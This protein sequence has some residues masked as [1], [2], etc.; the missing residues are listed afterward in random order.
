MP[1]DLL[2]T[3]FLAFGRFATNPSALLAASLGRRHELLA[4]S[5]AAV[6]AFLDR[7]ARD[8]SVKRLLMLGVCGTARSLR[9]ERFGRN[10]VAPPAD[11]TGETRGP[12]PIDPHGPPR[13][14][15]TL[16][17]AA[18]ANGHDDSNATTS[19]ATPPRT[20]GAAWSDDAGAYL[21]N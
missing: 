18:A 11:V 7:V 21:C 9:I 13:L 15:G 16:F 8:R 20:A 12:G 10:H 19:S 2:V 3:G 6:D 17:P 1:D 14:A 4:V 5:Y